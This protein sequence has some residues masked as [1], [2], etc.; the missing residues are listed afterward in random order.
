ML[1]ANGGLVKTPD[2]RAW[3]KVSNFV[4]PLDRI[5]DLHVKIIAG[6]VG[7]SAALMFKKSLAQ[8][9]RGHA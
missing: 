9:H 8:V 7:T 5:D 3:V 1:T 2:R 6:M 4:K